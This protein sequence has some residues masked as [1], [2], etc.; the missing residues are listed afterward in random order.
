MDRGEQP[1]SRALHDA[2]L[3]DAGDAGADL[4]PRP[5]ADR[6]VSSSSFRITHF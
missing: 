4:G 5:D 1:P 6:G 2:D 3:D